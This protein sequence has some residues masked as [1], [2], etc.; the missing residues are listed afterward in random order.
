MEPG[1]KL[2]EEEKLYI[3][4]SQCGAIGDKVVICCPKLGSLIPTPG[5]CGMQ[6]EDKI[7]YGNISNIRE[8][9]WSVMLEYMKGIMGI[10]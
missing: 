4:Y 7:F 2:S 6:F 9:P 5:V 8:F 1:V 10:I 3:Q